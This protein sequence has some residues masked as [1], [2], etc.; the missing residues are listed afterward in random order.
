MGFQCFPQVVTVRH[1]LIDT[2]CPAL[3]HYNNM[4]FEYMLGIIINW[5]CDFDLSGWT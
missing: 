5:K 3:G 4:H 2:F 1:G